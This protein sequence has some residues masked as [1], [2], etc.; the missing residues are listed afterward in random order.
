MEILKKNPKKTILAIIAII[1]LV[2]APVLISS[3]YILQA[4]ILIVLYA[5][6][7]MSWNFIGGFAGQVSLGHG[8]YIAIGAYVTSILYNQFSLTPWIGMLI[9][10]LIAGLLAILISYPCFKLS[11]TYFTLSTLAF[12]HIVRLLITSDNYLFGV[13][14]TNGA[15][16]M[17]IKWLG[18]NFINLQFMDKT[19]YVYV[20]LVLLVIVIGV[21]YKVKHSKMGYYLSAIKTNQKAAASLGINVTSYKLRA[22]FL[23]AFFTAIGGAVYAFVIQFIDP[24]TVL[25]PNMSTQILIFAVIGGV[26]TIWGPVIGAAVL[27]PINEITRVALGTE[28]TGLSGLIYGLIFMVVVFFMPNGLVPFFKEKMSNR[29]KNKSDSIS[30]GFEEKI[31]E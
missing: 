25:G 17:Q 15:Q 13:I 26:G 11:G 21:S 8:V 18:N 2:F 29:N 16:G 7:A 20:A 12:L 31:R 27:V 3:G 19:G 4:V 22:M 1:I 30:S 24:A 23:S 14:K 28:F 6:W 9:G 10:G 5:Y